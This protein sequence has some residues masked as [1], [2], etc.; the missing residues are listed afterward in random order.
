[1]TL[2]INQNIAFARASADYSRAERDSQIR[3]EH[4]ASGLGIARARDGGGRLSASEGMRAEIGGLV[5]GT[6]NTESALDLLRTAEGA[7]N[8]IST[9]LIRMRELAIQGSS[10]TLND[11]NREALDAEFG[12]LKEYTDRLARVATY[13]EQPLLSGFGNNV[14]AETSTALTES[15]TTGVYRTKLAGAQVGTYTFTDNPGDN[16]LTLSDGTASQ[17][18]SLGSRLVGGQV[19]TGTTLVANFDQLGLQ[20]ELAGADVRGAPGSYADG[21]LDGR[22]LVVDSGVGSFQLGSD[23]LP[24]DRIE[25][26]ISDMTIDSSVMN[27]SQVSITTLAS[28]R[29]AIGQVDHAIEG[30]ARERGVIGAVMNRLQRTLDFTANAIESVQASESTIRDVDYAWETSKLARN[31]IMLQ[32]S[33]AVMTKARIPIEMAM[34]LLQ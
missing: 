15:A 12:Q 11:R 32:G 30:V 21:D 26:R 29:T 34:S 17:T 28:A 13:N 9:M 16:T 2:R 18:I 7:M 20:I 31:Q 6:R 14:N 19:A 33:M 24:A 1:M 22:T 23:A 25:Y 5:Q 27:L 3:R 8:E 10:A 4:I